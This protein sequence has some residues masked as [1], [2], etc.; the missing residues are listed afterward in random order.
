MSASAD[1]RMF[2]LCSKSVVAVNSQ[3]LALQQC[4]QVF[5]ALSWT[6]R[7]RRANEVAQLKGQRELPE[8]TNTLPFWAG[9]DSGGTSCRSVIR[10]I[11]VVKT[12]CRDDAGDGGRA[13]G[14]PRIV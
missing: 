10:E 1:D 7:T 9:R 13:E 4:L 8:K 14:A 11:T 2:L 12:D 5:R 6:S 3:W